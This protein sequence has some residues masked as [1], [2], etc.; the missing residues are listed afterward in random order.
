[1]QSLK[2]FTQVFH[3][4][5][6][7]IIY[8]H[9]PFATAIHNIPYMG[10]YIN[11]Y[12]YNS[13]ETNVHIHVA[14]ANANHFN[15]RCDILDSVILHYILVSC[16]HETHEKLINGKFVTPTIKITWIDISLV[17]PLRHK[18]HGLT[19][20]FIDYP[21]NVD[22]LFIICTKKRVDEED[23]SP[24]SWYRLDLYITEQ[25]LRQSEK[26]LHV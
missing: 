2:T 20:D 24:H 11:I 22:I 19:M 10:T 15:I 14:F 21:A 8:A 4:L 6:A 3:I 16:P 13:R 7:T 25:C 26:T 9:T 12:I 5:H 17:T 1:M 18:Q 23:P